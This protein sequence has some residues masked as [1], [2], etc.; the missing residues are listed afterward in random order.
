M[1]DVR[2]LFVEDNPL[3]TELAIR[4]LQK[5]GFDMKWQRVETHADFMTRL[6]QDPPDIIISDDAMPQFSSSEALECLRESGLTI[7]FIVLSHAIGEEEAVQLM[8]SGAADYLRK[9]RMGRLGEAVR[10]ALEERRLRAQYDEAQEEL[11]FLNRDLEKRVVER[12]AELEAANRAKAH[13]LYE[14]Q[15]AEGRLRQLADTLEE[16]VQVRTQQVATSYARLRAL[17]TEL[18]IAEQTER[19]RIA[20]E[21]HDYLSQMLVVAR[22][23]VGH[24]LRQDHA[25]DVRKILQEAD[26]L[27]HQSLDYTR[28]LVSELTPQALYERGLSAALQWLGDQMRRQQILTVEISLDAPE[29]PLPEADAV[30]MFH[31]IRELLFNVLK[32]GKTD[33]ASVLMSYD[34]EVLSISVSDQGCGFRVSS[35]SEDRSD[36]FGL[37]SVR[38][39]MIALGGGFDLQSEPGKGTVASLH[40]PFR[41][42]STHIVTQPDGEETRPPTTA[43]LAEEHSGLQV[44]IPCAEDRD[45]VTPLRVLVVDDHQMVREGLCCLLREYDDVRVVGEASTGAQALQLA[46]TLI[47]NVVIVDMNMPGWDGAETTRRILKEHPTIVVIGLSIQSTP[48]VAE[49]MLNAGAAAFLQKDSIGKELYSTIQMA[50]QRMKSSRSITSPHL[51][52]KKRS[53]LSEG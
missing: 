24:L 32:H 45:V 27:L 47:P 2:I 43:P 11:R 33:R 14:R 40:L 5:S 29:L 8:R 23:K 41:M 1:D 7:P 9:D 46:G 21:L 38:E 17:A 37:L 28:T 51:P 30:L 16:Q 42:P 39:R 10:H 3:D 22:M 15:Q 36:R 44:T 18:T 19:R 50:V 52:S 53:R 20:T 26:Q 13:E 25:Q 6:T 4:E 48:H 35:L 31:S 49:S 12:T 34:Q